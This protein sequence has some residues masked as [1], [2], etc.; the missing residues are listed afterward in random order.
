MMRRILVSSGLLVAS[1]C[2]A[3]SAASAQPGGGGPAN[4]RADVVTSERIGEEIQLTGTVTPRRFS[5]LSAEVPGHVEQVLV[6]AGDIVTKGQ[7]LARLRSTPAEIRVLQ[8]QSQLDLAQAELQMLLNGTRPEDVAICDANAAEAR[9]KLELA[10]DESERAQ[11]LRATDS[12]SVSELDRA[13]AAM[14]TAQAEL[15]RRTAECERARN[16][17]R[18]EEIDSAQAHLEA[19]KAQLAELEDLLER[20]TIR[21]PF[22]GVIGM[23][24]TEVGQWVKLGDPLFA[25]AE[26]GVLRVEMA[27]PERY[28]NGVRV[29]S[30]ASVTLDAAPGRV[31]E[32]PVAYRV[33]LADEASRTFPVKLEIDNRELL[34]APGMLARVTLA[35]GDPSPEAA[36]LVPK[37]AIVMD[38]NGVEQVW[39]LREGDEGLAAFPVNIEGGRRW[40]ERVEVTGTDLRAGDRI[41]V[42]GNEMLYPGQKVAVEGEG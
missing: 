1:M 24:N 38:S 31:F 25:L 37:D 16:G 18:Q 4:V 30:K 2:L 26:V 27:L 33:P 6:D 14:L 10:R 12:T 11:K 13:R 8:A 7:P 20:H 23:K 39:V 15:D 5:L 40:R 19:V 28:F 35:V 22:A 17:P 3:P 36:L 21:A 42:R 41:V 9:A 29:G 34:L 32:A